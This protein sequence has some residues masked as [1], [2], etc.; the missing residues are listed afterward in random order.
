MKP[1]NRHARWN[2]DQNAAAPVEMRSKQAAPG[3][4]GSGPSVFAVV[5]H[6]G[7]RRSQLGEVQ[8]Q[9]PWGS[10]GRKR[11][12]WKRGMLLRLGGGPVRKFSDLDVWSSCFSPVLGDVMKRGWVETVTWTQLREYLIEIVGSRRLGS[13]YIKG[14]RDHPF[15]MEVQDCCGWLFCKVTEGSLCYLLTR[16]SPP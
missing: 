16:R 12:P 6:R 2:E 14:G 3:L 9:V 7:S 13:V 5:T 15:S 10:L 11:G 8:S 1:Q 4:L